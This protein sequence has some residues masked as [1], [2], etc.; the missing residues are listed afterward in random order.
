MEPDR[1]AAVHKLFTGGGFGPDYSKDYLPITLPIPASA[2]RAEVVAFITGHGFG[3]QPHNCAEFC[4]HTHHFTVNGAE[5][6]YEQPYV[7]DYYGC[8]K[9]VPFGT[10]PN[11]YGTWTIGR[12]G[13][14]P[15]LEV[16]P[17]IADVSQ[18]MATT[19]EVTYRGRLNGLD[20]QTGEPTYG[21]SIW[22]SSYLVTYE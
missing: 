17:F 11:Q 5:F 7:G 13:W 3:G 16:R 22:M 4:N 8:A 19:S 18:D 10:V 20:W 14:C 2:T 21:G 15:G 6:V 9:Q 12:G 1:P